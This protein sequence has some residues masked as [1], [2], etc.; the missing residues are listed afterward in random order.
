M[1]R[2]MRRTFGPRL[3]APL[4]RPPHQRHDL[5]LVPAAPA[6]GNVLEPVLACLGP[7]GV[8]P[9]AR[10]TSPGP[11]PRIHRPNRRTSLMRGDGAQTQR[12]G[13]IAPAS[14]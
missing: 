12:D 14:P 2:I 9:G 7:G 4:A 3:A 1:I 13:S 10:L 6:L 5:E 8:R 11:D